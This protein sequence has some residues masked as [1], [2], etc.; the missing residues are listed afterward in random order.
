MF[1]GLFQYT[2]DTVVQNTLESANLS[3]DALHHLEEQVIP[4]RQASHVT[5]FLLTSV[6]VY[7][8][9][10]FKASTYRRNIYLLFSRIAA[11]LFYVPILV[12]CSA[13]LDAVIVGTAIFGRLLFVCYYSWRYRNSSFI[14]LNTTTLMFLNGHAT[15][16]NGNSFVVLEGGDHFIQ[17][18]SDFVPFVSRDTVY[19][20]IRGRKE[21]DIQLLRTVELI[22]GK[23]LH[24][25]SRCEIVGITN[26]VFEQ[27]QLDEYATVSER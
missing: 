1:L 16:F 23:Y 3:D 15:Y 19:L 2:I 10:L 9:A 11:L 27:I 21:F 22:D 13:Y 8:F 6:F 20:A 5:G 7:F 18:G 14:I 12:V 24:V 4:L 26:S 25:F 17:F